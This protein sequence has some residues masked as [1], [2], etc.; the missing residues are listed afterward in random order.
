MTLSWEVDETKGVVIEI[1][2]TGVGIPAGELGKVLEPFGQVQTSMVRR[3][4]GSGL[5]LPLAKAFAELH[6]GTFE[7]A[8]EIDVGTRARFSLPP[9][10]IL[11]P[12]DEQN[13]TVVRLKKRA[14]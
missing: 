6:G 1:A 9:W 5:G 14:G 11:K 8:S 3:H 12:A 2:D 7:L 4:E 10:R 13:G